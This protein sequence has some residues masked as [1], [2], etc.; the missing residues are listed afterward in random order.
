MS[1]ERFAEIKLP[2]QFSELV[3]VINRIERPATPEVR[4]AKVEELLD[5]YDAI[6]SSPDYDAWRQGIS[7]EAYQ[8]PTAYGGS[9]P[10]DPFKDYVKLP[11]STPQDSWI[12]G[13]GGPYDRM[14]ADGKVYT[15][16]DGNLNRVE[17]RSGYAALLGMIEHQVWRITGQILPYAHAWEGE[18]LGAAG[19]PLDSNPFPF[20]LSTPQTQGRILARRPFRPTTPDPATPE[21]NGA[22]QI[23][24]PKSEIL[25]P[26]SIQ[27]RALAARIAAAKMGARIHQWVDDAYRALESPDHRIY[28]PNGAYVIANR[29]IGGKMRPDVFYVDPRKKE[30]LVIDIYTGSKNEVFTPSGFDSASHAEKGMSYANEP[31][32]NDL[33]RQGYQ[34]RGY[35]IARRPA[36]LPP[37]KLH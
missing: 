29:T 5:L 12:P 10:R 34:Y 25:I 3:N 8:N 2:A 27:R 13:G 35:F 23:L 19:P 36:S 30:F 24:N 31:F 9:D 18:K 6:L 4:A 32:S 28:L 21:R 22:S 16:R 26:K 37:K 15:F 14:A 7:P 33:K 20:D 1:C 11:R 17:N